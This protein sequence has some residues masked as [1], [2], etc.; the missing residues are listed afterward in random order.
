MQSLFLLI[1][2]VLEIYMWLVII[3]VI[4]SWLISFNVV[5]THNQVVYAINS[6]LHRITEP[7]LRPIRRVV[8]SIGGF[9]ITPVV[10]FLLIYFLRNLIHEY[11]VL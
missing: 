9:D 6:F 7:V 8:P 5:N 11:F 10:L 3:W 1:D 4:M 2:T